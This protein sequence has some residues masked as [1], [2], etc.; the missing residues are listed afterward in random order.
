MSV[1]CPKCKTSPV[2]A[3]GVMCD[4]CMISSGGVYT[5]PPD[6]PKKI[7]P[8]RQP[9][10]TDEV[11]D[12]FE[13]YT[14]SFENNLDIK[15]I[16]NYTKNFSEIAIF[17]DGNLTDTKT[18][19]DKKVFE[20]TLKSAIDSI[21]KQE[22]ERK[23]IEEEKI[24]YFKDIRSVVSDLGFDETAEDEPEDNESDNTDEIKL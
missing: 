20:S 8:I 14:K 24:K 18:Y 21:N 4:A 1:L 19:T 3:T 11:N 5:I 7:E 12:K 6:A 10:A 2:N 9:T 17:K 23:R 15:V 16:I 22:E 13:S